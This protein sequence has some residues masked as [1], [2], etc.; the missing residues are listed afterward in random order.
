MKTIIV[1]LLVMFMGAGC[2][3]ET[4]SVPKAQV[5]SSPNRKGDGRVSAIEQEMSI[6]PHKLS[7]AGWKTMLWGND[8]ARSIMALDCR[9]ERI[10]LMN[11][12]L[13]SISQLVLSLEVKHDYSLAFRNYEELI[14][15]CTIFEDEPEIVEKI[16]GIMCDCI[17]LHRQEVKKWADA[18][19][20]EPNRRNRVPLKNIYR[21]V[22]SDYMMFTNHVERTYFPWMKSHGLPLD[23]YEIWR[24]RIN[25]AEG[26]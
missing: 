19:D 25:D 24:Q 21:G 23:R 1:C 3:E 2:R 9:D 14:G 7:G 6:M 12:Y 5:D 15:T 8:L 17:R 13:E 16:L 18:I 4:T 11:R 26:R 20:N 22:C 10:R